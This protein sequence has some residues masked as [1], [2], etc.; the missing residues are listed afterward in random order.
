LSAKGE[1]ECK[2]TDVKIEGDRAKGRIETHYSDTTTWHP[3]E[4]IC[5]GGEWRRVIWYAD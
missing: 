3:I 2:L 5:V 1:K 4:F